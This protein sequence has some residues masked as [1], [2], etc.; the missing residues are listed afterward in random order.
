MYGTRPREPHSSAL[1]AC[2]GDDGGSDHRLKRAAVNHALCFVPLMDERRVG[3]AAC[4]PRVHNSKAHSVESQNNTKERKLVQRPA[5]D[6]ERP[7]V[8][9][10]DAANY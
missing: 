2:R 1:T 7:T 3:H 9:V 5:C 4:S 6:K 8:E 10:V